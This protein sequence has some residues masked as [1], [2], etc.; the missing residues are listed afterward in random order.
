MTVSIEALKAQLAML[1]AENQKLKA[2]AEAPV[3]VEQGGRVLTDE[4]KARFRE[5]NRRIHGDRTPMTAEERAVFD[6]QVK[7]AV[8][9]CDNENIKRT[10]RKG[11]NGWWI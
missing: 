2:Q 8:L 6:L 4:E 9:S 5:T 3:V 10:K 1:M 7:L 11:S